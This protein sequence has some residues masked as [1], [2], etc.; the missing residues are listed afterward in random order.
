MRRPYIVFDAPVAVKI[1]R[2]ARCQLA[3][4]VLPGALGIDGEGIAFLHID[5]PLRCEVAAVL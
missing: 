5:A 1:L 2:K 3:H 4:G